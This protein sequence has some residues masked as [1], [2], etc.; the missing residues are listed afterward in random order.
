MA[1]TRTASTRVALNDPHGVLRRL[2]AHFAEH[3]TVTMTEHGRR[4]ETEFGHA[5][6][7]PEPGALRI[8]AGGASDTALYVV[9]MSLAEHV[10]LLAGEEVAAF[11]WTGDGGEARHIPFFREMTV[12]RA[13]NV[14]PLMRRVTLAGDVAHFETGGLHVRLL[15]PPA[16][17]EPR[18]PS[19]AADGRTLWPTGED[20][21]TARIYTVRRIDRARGELDIDIVVHGDDEDAPGSRWALRATPGARVGL[22]GPGGGDVGGAERY[23]LAGDETALPAIA[24]IAEALPATAQA[25]ALIEVADAAEEQPLPSAARLETVWLHRNGA[26]PGTTRLIETALRGLDWPA[27][28]SGIYAL[29]GCEQEAARSIRAFLHKERGMAKKDC[30]VAAYWRRGQPGDKVD[31][32]G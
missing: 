22:M 16:G 32:H 11:A 20:E 6:L 2:C 8:E 17:R 3:G 7:V 31:R 18:W 23:V 26:A 30:L 13:G 27:D 29:V 10:F 25:V 14:T 5:T 24:R 15:I 4:I 1:E 21:L 19:A 28:L 12:R 9:K